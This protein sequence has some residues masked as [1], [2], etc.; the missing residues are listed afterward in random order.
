MTF[1]LGMIVQEGIVGIADSRL[2]FKAVN[3]FAEQIRQVSREDKAA[4]EE[5]GASPAE[6]ID[7]VF[8]N[9]LPTLSGCVERFDKPRIERI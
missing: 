6:R 8:V 1:C 3:T 5:S 9:V 2:T 7:R 4:L